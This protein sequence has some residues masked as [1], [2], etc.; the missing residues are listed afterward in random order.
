MLEIAL[1]DHDIPF[2]LL[3]G[4]QEQQPTYLE[5]GV[6][7][8][9]AWL[10]RLAEVYAPWID[11][12]ALRIYVGRES[13]VRLAQRPS[14]MCLTEAA[15]DLGERVSMGSPR[16]CRMRLNCGCLPGSV[17]QVFWPRSCSNG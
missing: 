9:T 17:D 13:A 1:A 15:Y 2:R 11:E 3:H 5:Y 7:P 16:S 10:L 12:A 8:L 14:G 4:A 6:L